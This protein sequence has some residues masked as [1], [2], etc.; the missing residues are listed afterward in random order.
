MRR[1]FFLSSLV[2][3]LAARGVAGAS[4]PEVEALRQQVKA[5]RAEQRLV[6]KTIRASYQ[7]VLA[8]AKL[9]DQE[10]AAQRSALDQQEKQYLAL[11]NSSQTRANIRA[12]YKLLRQALTGEI[13]V[14]T[15]LR[16]QLRAQ[17]SAQIKLVSGLYKAKIA[18]LNNLI[19]LAGA[20]GGT[21]R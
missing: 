11:T 4:N 7:A 6:T 13:R 19:R 3:A 12:Q 5:L 16:T 18:E 20:T 14:D 15:N 9:T 1:L 21:R 10:L 8:P 17:E 2:I